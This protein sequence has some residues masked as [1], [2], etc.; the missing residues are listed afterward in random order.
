[1]IETKQHIHRGR[2]H[3]LIVGEDDIFKQQL[4]NCVALLAPRFSSYSVANSPYSTKMG[5]TLLTQQT[6]A[7]TTWYLEGTTVWFNH[8]NLSPLEKSCINGDF[9][10]SAGTLAL[11]HR[12]VFVVPDLSLLK[13][14]ELF[15]LK[16]GN[17][18]TLSFGKRYSVSLF[19]M[20]AKEQID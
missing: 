6:D 5:L 10:L 12:G 1:V 18:C 9:F 11:A 4:L 8:S 3:L 20:E 19:L 13:K 14:R 15:I 2:I 16:Q 17:V 7:T